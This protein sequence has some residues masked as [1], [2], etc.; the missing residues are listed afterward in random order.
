MPKFNFKALMVVLAAGVLA[1]CSTVKQIEVR[2]YIQDK[3]R[4]DQE[5][6]G[7]A[8]YIFGTPKEPVVKSA[9]TTRRVYV[10]EFSKSADKVAV[11]EKTVVD[12]SSAA[13]PAVEA[14]SAQPALESSVA[15]E[16]VV[17]ESEPVMEEPAAQEPRVE[18]PRIDDE[19]AAEEARQNAASSSGGY[20]EYT[21]TKDDTLQKIAKK[22]YNSYSKWT[23]IYEANKEKIKSPD[24]IKPGMTIKIPNE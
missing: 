8:G 22:F 20:T 10:V 4:V 1:G 16:P 15:E 12:Q 7:N 23:K 3:E 19:P 5:M 2:S 24:H 21:V 17:Y 14:D 9:K 11:Q 18:I 13:Q 6:E